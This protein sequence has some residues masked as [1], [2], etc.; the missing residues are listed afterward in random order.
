[1]VRVCGVAHELVDIDLCSRSDEPDEDLG[2]GKL[3]VSD[4]WG[5]DMEIPVCKP[6]MRF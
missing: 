3:N 1:M 2:S 4:F 5:Q 6:I